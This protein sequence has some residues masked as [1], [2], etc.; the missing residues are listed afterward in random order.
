[1][2]NMTM[3]NMNMIKSAMKKLLPVFICILFATEVR[4]QQA[5]K[6][7]YFELGGPGIAS[8]NYDMRLM[9]KQDGLGF[10]IG[11]GGF[12]ID[13]IGAV[14]VPAGLNYLLGKDGKNY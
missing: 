13:D 8:F 7:I 3:N 10:R 11:I 6:T 5:A 4:A 14:F 2:I 9:K 12:K 1:M